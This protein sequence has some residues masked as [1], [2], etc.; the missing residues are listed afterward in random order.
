MTDLTFAR[1]IDEI[2]KPYEAKEPFFVEGVPVSP[3]KLKRIKIVRQD[4][5]FAPRMR[6]L[7][8]D[9]TWS[10]TPDAKREGLRRAYE[11]LIIAIV[12]DNGED[13]TSQ[14]IQAFDSKIKPRLTEYLVKRKEL[15]SLAATVF[16]RAYKELS[17]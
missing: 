5:G 6:R 4:D 10:N 11:T 8:S 15:I 14:V 3:E 13:V 17:S 16:I 1:L 7:H 12:R 2:V 9:L